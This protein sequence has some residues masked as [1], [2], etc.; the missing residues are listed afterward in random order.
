M[1]EIKIRSLRDKQKEKLK[2]T[3]DFFQN[4]AE[5]SSLPEIMKPKKWKKISKKIL[6]LAFAGFSMFL[7]GGLG[8]IWLDR[9]FFPTLLVKYPQ[10]GRYEYLK[11]MNER[12]TVVKETEEIR[13]SQEQDISDT[14]EKVS[15]S[16][17]EVWTKNQSGQFEK[18]GSG[19]IL[20]SDGYVITPL[21]NIYA[22]S[23]ANNIPVKELQIK[24]SSGKTY[25]AKVA[26]QNN[27]YSLAML[28]IAENNLS[29]IP[30]SD[31][32][33]LKLGQKMIIVNDAVT[34][35]I[36]SKFIDD[37]K[38]PSSTDSSLQKRIQIVQKLPDTAAGSAV[39]NLEGRL[40]GV[41][42]GENIVIPISEIKEFIDKSVKKE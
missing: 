42:Q 18:A 23:G 29:V 16:I 11:Q 27:N 37:Y 6:R 24:L 17:V 22:K 34:T 9:I 12:V 5:S 31:P 33:D 35:D 2:K 4:K 14:I 25:D 41:E 15:P 36:I 28:K 40:V 21:Q 38:M 20:T 19:I 39:I 26:V 10:L 1:E 32:A 7:I 3:E 13:I 30:Y 8:G